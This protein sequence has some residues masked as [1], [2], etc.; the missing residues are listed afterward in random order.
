MVPFIN[1]LIG[2]KIIIFLFGNNFLKNS[3]C[4]K[5]M[6]ITINRTEEERR[7]KNC[8]TT[9]KTHCALKELATL[10]LQTKIQ[11]KQELRKRIE[12]NK[13]RKE[14]RERAAEVYQVVRNPH[15]IKKL[16]RKDLVKRDILGKVQA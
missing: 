4:Y 9:W 5:K 15:K 11:H 2:K 16:K 10:L 12:E 1:F 8:D 14:E 13:K 6:Y 7:G 3:M